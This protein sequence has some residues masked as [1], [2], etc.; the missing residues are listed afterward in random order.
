MRQFPRGGVDALLREVGFA[1][2]SLRRRTNFTLVALA[3]LT[4]G[5]GTA[6]SIYSVVDAVLFRPLPFREPDRLV[7]VWLTYPHWKQEPVLA[8]MW[9]RI[10]LSHPEYRQWRERQRTFD[11]VAIHATARMRL[12][13]GEAPERVDVV[14]ASASMLDVLGAAPFM[15][16]YF[17]PEEDVIGGPLVTVLSFENWESRYG[18]DPNVLGRSVRFEEGTY[19]VI[20]VLPRGLSL[21]HGQ[22]TAPYWFAAGQ[23][24]ARSWRE[25]NHNYQALGRLRPGATVDAATQ[26]A[27]PLL[28]GGPNT[29][30]RHGVRL[31]QWHE[32]LTRDVRKPLVLLLAAVLLLMLVA[33]VNVATLMLGEASAR[34]QEIAARIALGADRWRIVRLLLTESVVLGGIGAVLGS[35]AA[36][37]G[38]KALVALAPPN[39]PGIT[40]AHLDFR[41]LGFAAFLSLVT[42]VLFGL[43]PAILLA[44]KDSSTILR[45]GRGQSSRHAAA[46]QPALVAA[47]LALSF[48]LLVGAAMLSRSF[49]KLT[50]VEPGFRT[51][52]LMVMR[53]SIPAAKLRD[54]SF[55]RS[56]YAEA[57]ARIAALPGVVRATAG[58]TLPFSGGSASSGFEKEGETLPPN[59]RREVQ[60]RFILPG[61]LGALGIELLGGR[62]FEARDDHASRPVIIVSE[63]LVRRD[64]PEG[65]PI[66]R[67]VRW[68]GQMREIVGVVADVKYSK[69]SR[70]FDPTIYTPQA[71]YS[72]EALSLLVR[73]HGDPAARLGAVRTAVRAVDPSV[74]VVSA[75]RMSDLIARSFAEERYRTLLIDLFGISAALL[76]AAGMYGVVTRAVAR[77]RRELGIRIALGATSRAIVGL[78]MSSTVA[79][80]AAGIGVGV[81]ASL[82]TSRFLGA[83]VFGVPASD[84]WTYVAVAALLSAVTAA[85]SWIPA[86]R[87]GRTHPVTVLRAE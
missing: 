40:G 20:G 51:E 74:I 26:D 47:E 3:V 84:P 16:R 8:R 76:A 87:A 30:W 65:S 75:D 55:M 60:Q 7:A 86:R 31:Q 11:D 44:R 25:H 81:L 41:V 59:E 70:A 61:Y 85:A 42:A 82:A 32:D 48:V 14:Q 71:Q 27:A 57:S 19:T 52:N 80:L 43:A 77:R 56:F 10:G 12:A 17:A 50:A 35:A 21:A 34:E 46:L 45:G 22:P 24:S 49:L 5:I 72:T 58:S 62:D 9:D 73:T 83:F 78:V 66:G 23:D 6:T 38:T 13:G 28:D 15:G 36:W 68:L 4:L 69:L 39:L 54:S 79:G 67:S 33:C 29:P 37:G 63:A 64:F 1:L 18:R 2:R 53:L